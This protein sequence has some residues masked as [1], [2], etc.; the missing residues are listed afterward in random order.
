MQGKKAGCDNV[1]KYA[2]N[3]A[4]Y[5]APSL[6]LPSTYN[7]IKLEITMRTVRPSG[8]LSSAAAGTWHCWMCSSVAPA[9]VLN[10]VQF[11]DLAAAD[12]ESRFKI[13]LCRYIYLPIYM[14]SV[15]VEKFLCLCCNEMF[16][17]LLYETMFTGYEW[18]VKC[19]IILSKCFIVLGSW[20]IL[21]RAVIAV[22]IRLGCC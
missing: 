9:P 22:T 18:T 12:N 14:F 3:L 2:S 13:L 11:C 21:I 1:A 16:C 6:P 5:R 17:L 7:W 15:K 4:E 10:T 19:V 20:W 8:A